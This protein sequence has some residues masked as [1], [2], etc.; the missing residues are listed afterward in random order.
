MMDLLAVVSKRKETA[1]YDELSVYRLTL[2][3]VFAKSIQGEIYCM[4]WRPDGAEI[5][6][7]G[8][9]LVISTEIEDRYDTSRHKEEVSLVWIINVENGDILRTCPIMGDAN[10]VEQVIWLGESIFE[11]KTSL[12]EDDLFGAF[13]SQFPGYYV[14]S[15]DTIHTMTESTNF[16]K[17]CSQNLHEFE[18]GV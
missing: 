8:R 5:V 4:T 18:K 10:H 13:I 12:P 16:L 15:E 7:G 17:K 2:Q 1:R 9:G 14:T 6:L 11:E 3:R